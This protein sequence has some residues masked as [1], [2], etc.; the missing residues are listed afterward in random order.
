MKTISIAIKD[1][2]ILFKDRGALFQLFI[3]PLLFIMVFS[4]ALGAIGVEKEVVLPNLA[5]VDHDGGEAAV[6]LLSKNG[7]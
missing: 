1:L 6:F 2:K 7:C 4:G 3:L 5:V